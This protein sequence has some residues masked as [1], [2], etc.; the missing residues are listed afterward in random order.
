MTMKNYLKD[1]LADIFFPA[2]CISCNIPGEW[3]C[4]DCRSKV[5]KVNEKICSKCLKV[6]EHE[7]EG[8]LPF[9]CV[10]AFGFYHDPNLRSVITNIKFKG[11]YA[12]EGV[13]KEFIKENRRLLQFRNV[14]CL[15]PLPL[16]EKRLKDRG[17]NQA[18]IVA[19]VLKQVCCIDKPLRKNLLKRVLHSEPQ[20]SLSNDYKL[21]SCN[22]LDSFYCDSEVPERVLLVDDVVTTGATAGEAARVLLK[23]GAKEVHLICLAIGA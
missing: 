23:N 13:V 9:A 12:L 11:A 4:V 5:H 15:V 3:W 16:S 1:L 19:E 20:S 18:L 8:V 22:I 21:R 6:G 17:F 10:Q 2:F 7:C 14:D